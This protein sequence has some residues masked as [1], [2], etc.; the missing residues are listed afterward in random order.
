MNRIQSLQVDVVTSQLH[1]PFVTARRAA[2]T[3][4]SIVLR[5]TDENGNVGWGE[6]PQSWRVTGDSLASIRACLEGPLTDLLTGADLDEDPPHL[7]ASVQEV[8]VG[9]TGARMAADLA[10]HDLLARAQGCSVADFLGAPASPD[11]EPQR[12]ATDVTI[13]STGQEPAS[14]ARLRVSEGFGHLKL[15]LGTDPATDVERVRAVREA[16]GTDVGIRVDANQGWT[17]DEAIR[18]VTE[19]HEA[20]L[21][22]ELI[23]QPVFRRDLAGM[24]RV[25]LECPVPVMADE[26]VFCLFD[27]EDLARWRDRTGAPLD[28]VNIKLAKCGGLMPALAM[29]RRAHELGMQV[30]V[31]SMMESFLGVAAAATLHLAA[32]AEITPDLDAAWWSE[33]SP[34]EGGPHYEGGHLVLGAGPGFGID[35]LRT[36][37]A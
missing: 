17:V 18:I 21:G 5:I 25:A 15:K 3:A 27:L 23:E 28:R 34:F 26:S 16:V 33:S 9:N 12:V 24:A 37:P 22:V 32:G 30:M 10:I 7:L 14:A 19:L 8:V 4:E 13:S 20:G 11:G 2:T 1:T 29:A 31:G 36:E 6:G 35:A